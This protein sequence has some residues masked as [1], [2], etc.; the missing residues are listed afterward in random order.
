MEMKLQLFAYPLGF[1]LTR[2][3]V[4]EEIPEIQKILAGIVSY[5]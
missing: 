3:V 2:S 1:W 5:P 4:V